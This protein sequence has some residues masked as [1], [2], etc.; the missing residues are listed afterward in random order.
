MLFLILV[1]LMLI[2]PFIIPAKERIKRDE[3]DIAENEPQTITITVCKEA[4][5]G[6]SASDQE[7]DSLLA[8]QEQGKI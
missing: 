5:T 6:L 2:E 3:I 1:V 7:R 4:G 8:E